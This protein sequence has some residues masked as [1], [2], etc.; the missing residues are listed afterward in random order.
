MLAQR[1]DALRQSKRKDSSASNTGSV[2]TSSKRVNVN[3]LK[4]FYIKRLEV[5]KQNQASDASTGRGLSSTQTSSSS[6]AGGGYS[7][8]PT[9]GAAGAAARNGAASSS[10]RA[11]A[12]I[13]LPKSTDTTNLSGTEGGMSG[14]ENQQNLVLCLNTG[15]LLDTETANAGGGAT[16][17]GATSTEGGGGSSE[18]NQLTVFDI[19]LS[20]LKG[21]IESRIAASGLK[22]TVMRHLTQVKYHLETAEK[23]TLISVDIGVL[24][25]HTVHSLQSIVSSALTLVPGEYVIAKRVCTVVK[26]KEKFIRKVKI[27]KGELSARPEDRDL[28]ANGDE[29]AYYDDDD[30]AKSEVKSVVSEMVSDCGTQVTGTEVTQQSTFMRGL[31]QE[32][33]AGTNAPLLNNTGGSN[34]VANLNSLTSDMTACKTEEEQRRWFYSQCLNIK[35]NCADKQ[36]ARKTLISDM[37]AQC[38]AE[39]VPMSEWIK[40]INAKFGND[41]DSAGN[42]AGNPPLGGSMSTARATVGLGSYGGSA[43]KSSAGPGGSGNVAPN[44]NNTLSNNNNSSNLEDTMHSS[45][46]TRQRPRGPVSPTYGRSRTPDPTSGNTG[47]TSANLKSLN[48]QNNMPSGQQQMAAR[49]AS[50]HPAA[51]PARPASVHPAAPPARQQRRCRRV[52]SSSSPPSSS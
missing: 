34:D 9:G 37:Y 16:A 43:A 17:N 51:P 24:S 21:V 12:R 49:P 6:I 40:W 28:L 31:Q 41:T 36:K 8:N 11:R 18:E 27:E 35:L 7:S 45:V 26:A 44:T 52:Y 20:S 42:T 38:R 30:I 25:E 32:V 19:R 29:N 46:T 13:A 22:A 47:L 4:D 10:S 48:Q 15:A 5:Q 3:M 50:V 14:E 33:R 2:S 23:W 39:Q 1:Y